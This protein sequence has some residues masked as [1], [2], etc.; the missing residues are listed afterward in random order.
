MLLVFWSN[1]AFT[2]ASNDIYL[3]GN[4]N[5]NSNDL[6]AYPQNNRPYINYNQRPSY[7]STNIGNNRLPSNP[8]NNRVSGTA[9]RPPA[10]PTANRPAINSAAFNTASYTPSQSEKERYRATEAENICNS[11]EGETSS[12]GP[13][14]I[15]WD[16]TNQKLRIGSSLTIENFV[17]FYSRMQHSRTLDKNAR[18][19]DQICEQSK[20]F[21]SVGVICVPYKGTPP[22]LMSDVSECPDNARKSFF[23]ICSKTAK[24]SNYLP[25]VENCICV[26]DQYFDI[27]AEEQTRHFRL[28][29]KPTLQNTPSPVIANNNWQQYVPAAALPFINRP[30]L[31]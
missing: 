15:C 24:L 10:A 3:N 31:G 30:N 16:P 18:F 17:L 4:R 7:A 19:R 2:S 27:V 13:P 25:P 20:R 14:G 21:N 29:V 28:Y 12:Q 8:T 26:L 9:Q 11:A 1:I 6:Q 23:F 22:N 5:D